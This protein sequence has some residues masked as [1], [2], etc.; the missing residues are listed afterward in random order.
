M[1]SHRLEVQA[2]ISSSETASA[3]TCVSE[4]SGN[5]LND[6]ASTR[7]LA[8]SVLSYKPSVSGF[9]FDFIEIRMLINFLFI[10]LIAHGFIKYKRRWCIGTCSI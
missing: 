9:C 2:D 4:K 7:A 1:Y 8:G 6:T 3:V 10:Y 5:T